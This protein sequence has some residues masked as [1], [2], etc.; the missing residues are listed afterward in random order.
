MRTFNMIY[1]MQ[2]RQ[3][4]NFHLVALKSMNLISLREK[5]QKPVTP[6]DYYIAQHAQTAYIATMCKLE[7]VFDLLLVAQIVNTKKRCKNTQQTHTLAD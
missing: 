5:I 2:K 1:R 7:A 3:Y 6:E 4:K